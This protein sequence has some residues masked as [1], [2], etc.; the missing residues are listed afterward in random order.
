MIREREKA[1]K[2]GREEAMTKERLPRLDVTRVDI[3]CLVCKIAALPLIEQLRR[4]EDPG[5]L[6]ASLLGVG[7]ILPNIP[8]CERHAA[9]LVVLREQ[10]RDKLAEEL[11]KEDA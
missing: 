10:A 5:D 6:V 1:R 8:A 9:W 2:S 11:L 3:G 4:N 7:M